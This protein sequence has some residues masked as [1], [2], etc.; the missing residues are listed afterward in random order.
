MAGSDTSA[1]QTGFSTSGTFIRPH[2]DLQPA[3]PKA[4]EAR[5][6]I[7]PDKLSQPHPECRVSMGIG[8]DAPD[9]HDALAQ[10]ALDGSVILS[11]GN[12]DRLIIANA[13]PRKRMDIGRGAQGPA[14]RS[15]W[16]CRNSTVAA[17][18][19]LLPPHTK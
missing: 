16:A 1:R 7:D 10:C 4:L 11:A 14:L 3:I 13:V 6:Q 5:S 17:V 8:H 9:R 15:G 18:N 12:D 2:E 19:S